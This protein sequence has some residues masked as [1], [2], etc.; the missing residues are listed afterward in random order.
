MKYTWITNNKTKLIVFFNG[1]GCDEHQ[2]AHLQT[3]QYDILLLNDYRSL[4][5]DA[6]VVEAIR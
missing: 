4:S 6:T 5:I 3:E 1:W 2:F